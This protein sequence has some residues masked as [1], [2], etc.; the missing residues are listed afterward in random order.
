MRATF[1]PPL[2]DRPHGDWLAT[3]WV[4]G[5]PWSPTACAAEQ[6][7]RALCESGQVL[8]VSDVWLHLTV[9]PELLGARRGDLLELALLYCP[10]GSQPAGIAGQRVLQLA[11]LVN[12]EDCPRT[13]NR[14]AFVMGQ[15]GTPLLAQEAMR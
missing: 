13:S 15:P 7:E 5:V 11:R 4:N 6:L 1:D 9:D 8:P 12:D 3:F 2:P 10:Q 14:L